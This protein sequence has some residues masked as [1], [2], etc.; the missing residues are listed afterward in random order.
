[1]KEKRGNIYS[2]LAIT[3]IMKNY[4]TYVPYLLTCI[5]MV[6]MYYIFH[7]LTESER[8][9]AME[10]GDTL[11]MMLPLG[12][13]VF[14]VFA[15][16]FLFYTN[17]FLI[18]NRKREFG[19]YNILG[20]GK[21]NLAR[22]LLWENG[23]VAAVSLAAGIFCGILFSKLAELCMA[24]IL[25]GA[26]SMEFTVETGSVFGTLKLFLF[27]YLLILLNALLQMGKAKP[28]DLLH[29][30]A[31][32]E[33]PPKANWLFA[34]AGFALL[35]AAYYIAVT[36]QD[37]MSAFLLFFVAVGMVVV[38][39]YLI[40]IA[41]S[42]ALCRM[43]Q[44]NKKYY[45]KPNH[46][47]SVSSMMYRMKRNGAG[48]ASIC[49]LSTMV[50]VMLSAA[51]CLY[52]GNEARLADR[53]PRQ[54]ELCTYSFD[55][56]YLRQL[57]DAVE[58]V[59]EKSGLEQ[60][61]ILNYRYLS[62]AGYFD[63][64]QVLLDEERMV[65]SFGIMDTAKIR[66]IYFIPVSDYNRIMGKDEALEGDEVILYTP[67]DDT[68]QYDTIMMEGCASW[69]VKKTVD[70]FPRNGEEVSTIFNSMYLFVPDETFIS[71]INAV[72][73]EIYGK[74]ASSLT[75]YYGFD[76][77]AGDETQK[78]IAA[79]VDGAI[80]ALTTEDES[81]PV[82]FRYCRAKQKTD[83]YALYGGI[84]ALGV[85]LAIVFLAATV[86]IMYYKQITEGLE[87]QSRFDIMQKVGMTD[88]EIRSSIH[89]QMLT[90][91]LLPLLLAGL[92]TTFAFPIVKKLLLLFGIINSRVLLYTN[93]S[94][95]L[96][97]TLFYAAV[98]FITSR[99][100]YRI[101]RGT[102]KKDL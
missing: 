69:Q 37:P 82:T 71:Q 27:I 60:K 3:G 10:G 4:R 89:S 22:I 77:E 98:Y 48:L 43:L 62:I 6:M 79:K 7:F 15:V 23:I 9:A 57:D 55:E 99:S 84:F 2:R 86:L 25:H 12:S 42:V 67:K 88:R 91:F 44:K 52:F 31:A 18:R 85:L 19:L 51:T 36:I 32:G 75:R 54:I 66:E 41:G 101:V 47:V 50:L 26:V 81:F 102:R 61:N 45:Y 94:C 68:Y 1:M 16:I 100:Y 95:F 58:H 63:K 78:Q 64:D 30:S 56:K 24:R 38:A 46:F 11:Q 90:V 97:F 70:S 53:Y 74:N 14:A 73:K 28:V 96:V 59:M 8:V 13:N 80:D 39:T 92:H 17:S 83:F 21:R 93:I 20:M 87:D 29:S 49:V 65:G 34:L 40:F 72:Q 35:A 76:L 33:K 5:G